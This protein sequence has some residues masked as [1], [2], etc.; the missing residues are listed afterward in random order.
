MEKKK[1][2]HVAKLANLFL[3]DGEIRIFQ[4]QLGEILDYVQ[5]L[6]NI[7]ADGVQPTSQVTD[8]KNV[9]REDRIGPSLTAKQTVGSAKKT[10]GNY[11][12]IKGISKK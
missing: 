6:N 9:F 12:A 5:Q 3:S 10:S 1:V 4:K 7:K 8:L 11:F 2:E